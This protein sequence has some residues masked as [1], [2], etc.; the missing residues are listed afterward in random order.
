MAIALQETQVA[1]KAERVQ[2]TDISAQEIITDQ[3]VH[4]EQ[5][6]TDHQE[7]KVATLAYPSRNSFKR[8]GSKNK[9]IF[10]KICCLDPSMF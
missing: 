5:S 8:S 9:F 2:Q 1:L 4:K 7:T 10:I 6:I 3:K